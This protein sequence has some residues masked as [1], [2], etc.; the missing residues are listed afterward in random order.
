MV[1]VVEVLLHAQHGQVVLAEGHL[2]VLLTLEQ[3]GL[4]V[5]VMMVQTIQEEQPLHLPRLGAEGQG[6]LVHQTQEV[7]S[8]V[9]VV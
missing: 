7:V 2:I 4:L 5:R 1:E 8:L 6:Q 3:L 9:Q